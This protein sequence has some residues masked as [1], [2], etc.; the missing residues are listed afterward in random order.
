MPKLIGTAPNQVPTNG[1]L[2][3]MAFQNKEGVIV[4]L[5]S[6]TSL[7]VTG[8]GVM[9]VGGNQIFK[10]ASGNVGIGITSPANKLQVNGANVGI[11]LSDTS[12]TTD[13]HEIQSGGVNG[14]NLFI[15]AD[16]NNV[17]SGNMI[18]RVAGATER[19]RIT[20]AGTVGIG[21]SSPA[22]SSAL[23]VGRN[24]TGSTFSSGVASS[25]QVQSDVTARA[26][27]FLSASSVAAGTY[28]LVIGYQA[29]QST[30]TGTV[31]AQYGFRADASLVGATS[32]M[33]FFGSIPDG[34]NRWNFYAQ[35]TAPN[36]F[37]GK[38]GI[39][40]S[41]PSFSLQVVSAT[42]AN[43]I[44]LIAGPTRA[45]RFGTDTNGSF[46]EGVDNTGT[47]SY[48]SLT[49]GGLDLRFNTNNTERMRLDSSG[50]VGIG[51]TAPAARVHI[52]NSAI[53]S[54]LR[55][56]DVTTDATTKYGA[57]STAHYTNAQSPILAVGVG[58]LSA[59]NTVF[60]GGG[61]G[62]L[63]AATAI[64]FFT[65]ANN[66][67]LT[68][69]ERMRI[70]NAGNVGI[71]T[72]NPASTLNVS[73]ASGDAPVNTS[74]SNAVRLTSTTTA[75]VGVGPSIFFEGQ[76]GNTTAN[77]GFAAI[78]GFKSSATLNDYSGSLAFFTQSSGGS[79]ALNERMRITDAGNVGIGTAS[80]AARLDVQ[81]SGGRFQVLSAVSTTGIR[82]LPVNT[83]NSATVPIEISG[84][85]IRFTNPLNSVVG[86]FDANGNLGIGTASPSSLGSNITTL[87]VSGAAGGGIRFQR[88]SATATNG[89]ISALSGEFRVGVVD[90][91]PLTFFTTNTERARIDAS[92]NLLVGTTS[93]SGS[94]S[95]TA[96]V[97]GGVF[98]TL[99]SSASVA[100]NTATTI[101]TLPSGEGNYMVSASL[102]S[103]GT[104]A[105]Y[106]EVAMVCVSQSNTSITTLVNASQLSLSM[107][108]LNLQVTHL[109]GLTQTIQYSVLRIL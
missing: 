58:S 71:G 105:D 32:N 11:R 20:S 98:S 4:D 75:A 52:V 42:N 21:T 99:R 102:V 100:N 78:Q 72:G 10:D 15:D 36:Y 38:V 41:V 89:Y 97:I 16:R 69:T 28:P 29:Q 79:T 47:A 76:T 108:G 64:Q 103:S 74:G 34:T 48:Q 14:Q 27:Y 101:A 104:P 18:F 91:L 93:S 84:T 31:T 96:R 17:G 88:T 43:P 109:Q 61:F 33:G 83:A 13:F 73:T 30:F 7:T 53:G 81:A 50:N 12:G 80:P 65:A 22:A 26:D 3:N 67:T 107:S 57:I 45:V 66:A 51:T 90:A 8:T 6:T 87:D 63:N 24:I 54:Q 95:N 46:V 2:G 86:I 60:I 37:A 40:T 77:Y 106:N 9:S 94:A 19:M 55:L 85:D 39:G 44:A 59:S 35:G 23:I 62:A 49:I 56:Q 68:G 25:G 1:L 70:T 5:L 82:L 92:G